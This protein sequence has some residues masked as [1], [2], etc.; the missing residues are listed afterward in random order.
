MEAME[1]GAVSGVAM[2]AM[3]AG[4]VSGVAMEAMEAG[5][6]SGVAGLNVKWWGPLYDVRA[7][8]K[9]NGQDRVL[10]GYCSKDECKPAWV[11][12][13][14]QLCRLSSLHW[15][16]MHYNR[17]WLR[18]SMHYNRSSL[19]Y[20]RSIDSGG[21]FVHV[22]VGWSLYV[23]ITRAAQYLRAIAYPNIGIFNAF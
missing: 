16:S 9:E 12:L 18:Y 21:G 1:A 13:L 11:A 20:H 8:C 17:S 23:K 4:A 15:N 7:V 3:E 10:V 19:L 6:V 5:A 14:H 2:V 22:E